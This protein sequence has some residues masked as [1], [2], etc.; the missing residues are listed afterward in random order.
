VPYPV[1]PHKELIIDAWPALAA[2]PVSIG[3]VTLSY[4]Q[5][6]S[7][8]QRLAASRTSAI[9]PVLHAARSP[10]AACDYFSAAAPYLPRARS[11]PKTG[12]V[13][14][15]GR[16]VT[17]N[18]FIDAVNAA[19]D[20][21]AEHAV[22][23]AVAAFGTD[24][25]YMT[26]LAAEAVCVRE[27]EHAAAVRAVV[28]TSASQAVAACEARAGQFCCALESACGT[29]ACRFAP[30]ELTGAGVEAGPGRVSRPA[31]HVRPGTGFSLAPALAKAMADLPWTPAIHVHDA[32]TACVGETEAAA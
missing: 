31:N 14:A 13:G 28:R 1:S 24:A 27:K 32:D 12:R 8:A 7:A 16:H 25:R 26:E 6:A 4:A 5:A 30:R 9:A 21:A 20:L 19:L 18:A 10:L 29:G 11:A 2:S 15:A 3:G 22:D 17:K 23:E